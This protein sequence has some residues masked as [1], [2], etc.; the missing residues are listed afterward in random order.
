[1]AVATIPRITRNLSLVALAQ[2][3][4]CFFLD[5]PIAFTFI[6]SPAKDLSGWQ[7]A[8]KRHPHLEDNSHNTRTKHYLCGEN[9]THHSSGVVTRV[10]ISNER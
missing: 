8:K 10:G 6:V 2:L 1:M 4:S 5:Q 9:S 3:Q 7:Q